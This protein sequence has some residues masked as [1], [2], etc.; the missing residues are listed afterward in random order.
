MT[1]LN[2]PRGSQPEGYTLMEMMLVL[3]II[4]ILITG[5][6]SV[7]VGVF[8]DAERGRVKTDF[9]TITTNLYRYRR[10]ANLFPTTEQGLEALV[11]R[12]SIAPQPE[13]WTPY[14]KP[15]GIVDPWGNRYQYV[16]PG[17]KNPESFDLISAGPDRKLGTADDLTN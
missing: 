10:D 11:T 4:A 17:K 16:Y 12:P 14:S 1:E 15:A 7:M 8:G 3:G 9:Q 13:V 2:F 6:V 5:G